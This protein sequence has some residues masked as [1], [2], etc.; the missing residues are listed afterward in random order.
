M[1]SKAPEYPPMPE[2]QFF[3][4]G[5][6]AALAQTKTHIIRYWEREIPPLAK[7]SRRGG[8]RRYYTAEQVLLLRRVHDLIHRQGYTIPGAREALQASKPAD[9]E[10]KSLRQ[11]LER[12]MAML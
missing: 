4:I 12:I 7:V 9:R 10:R 11:E 1:K 8:G 5:E 6:A 2:K 3:T